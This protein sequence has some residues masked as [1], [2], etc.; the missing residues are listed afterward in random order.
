M[1]AHEVHADIVTDGGQ[2]VNKHGDRYQ[3]LQKKSGSAEN[4]VVSGKEI[5]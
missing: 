2:G 1:N 3:R 4:W 5:P